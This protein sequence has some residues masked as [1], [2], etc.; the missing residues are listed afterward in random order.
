MADETKKEVTK[1]VERGEKKSGIEPK[2]AKKGR[3]SHREVVF[4]EHHREYHE[5][6]EHREGD[7]C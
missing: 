5:H 1:G 4:E 3:K 7:S 6:H 2:H